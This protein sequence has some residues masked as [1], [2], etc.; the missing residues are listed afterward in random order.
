MSRSD[1]FSLIGEQQLRTVTADFYDRVFADVMIGFLFVGKDK[2]H[3]ID[4][5]YEFTANFLGGPVSYTGRPIKQAHAKTPIFGGHF[6][7]RLQIM[8][9]TMADHDVHP[10]VV[11]SIIQHQQALRAL[12][13]GDKGSE[14]KDTLV[15]AQFVTSQQQ[16][17]TVLAQP[18]AKPLQA[19]GLIKLG[20]RRK[21]GGLP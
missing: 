10:E 6:E 11:D 13:T 14:C 20:V 12:V 17:L 19:E 9:N 4:R 21:P 8:R 16:G 18:P 2:Q 15:A 1:L 7:R 5:E 3:L